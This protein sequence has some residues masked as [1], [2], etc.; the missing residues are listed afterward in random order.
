LLE[1]AFQRQVSACGA[2]PLQPTEAHGRPPQLRPRRGAAQVNIRR[3]DAFHA[4]AT[5]NGTDA[6]AERRF[7]GDLPVWQAPGRRH[8]LRHYTLRGAL[9][10]WDGQG[11]AMVHP[12]H[13]AGYQ[14]RPRP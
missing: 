14:A 1:I 3:Y 12:E 11:K 10:Y 2:T 4:S 13:M 5:C 6:L 9:P 7:A 8:P